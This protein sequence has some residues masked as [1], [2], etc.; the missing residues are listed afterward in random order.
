[1]NIKYLIET[2]RLSLSGA[3]LGIALFHILNYNEI[4]GMLFGIVLV[5][6]YK[7]NKKGILNERNIKF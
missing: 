5:L 3:I 7:L 2:I 4:I 6:L 1:M